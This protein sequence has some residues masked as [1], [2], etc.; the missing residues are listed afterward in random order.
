M[1]VIMNKTV[2]VTNVDGIIP[3]YSQY[4]W[5]V[6]CLKY[7]GGFVNSNDFDY[8]GWVAMAILINT[9]RKNLIKEFIK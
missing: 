7:R 1:L 4:K 8:E 9:G 5:R 6:L 3:T 2:K